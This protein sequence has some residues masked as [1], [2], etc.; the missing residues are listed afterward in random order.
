MPVNMLSSR[1]K[2]E[3]NEGR[4]RAKRRGGGGKEGERE[5]PRLP[6][7]SVSRRF[8]RGLSPTR[9]YVNR[10]RKLQKTEPFHYPTNSTKTI[11]RRL[12]LAT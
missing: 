12:A 7:S 2:G 11:L 5:V 1:G 9:G 3:E 6:L 4:E 8:S 10:L